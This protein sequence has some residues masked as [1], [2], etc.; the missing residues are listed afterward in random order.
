MT[1]KT[2]P[3]ANEMIHFSKHGVIEDSLIFYHTKVI[4]DP[5]RPY[6]ALWETTPTRGV[7]TIK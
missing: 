3:K 7:N 4:L 6:E 1:Y 2:A 5:Y